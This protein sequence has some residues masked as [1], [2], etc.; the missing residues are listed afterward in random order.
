[1]I[2]SQAHSQAISP[3][4]P[5]SQSLLEERERLHE[6]LAS[7]RRQNQ[8]LQERVFAATELHAETLETDT[9]PSL[10]AH[11]DE[12]IAAQVRKR[13]QVAPP[14][15]LSSSVRE[16]TGGV[17]FHSR[18]GTE[19]SSQRPRSDPVEAVRVVCRYFDSRDD[20]GD[21]NEEQVGDEEEDSFFLR[22]TP[23][24]AT[25]EDLKEEILRFWRVPP[26]QRLRY[27][28]E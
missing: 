5:S 1:M 16:S 21:L 14:S 11:V 9:L 8:E 25:F 10:Y 12:L 23:E 18:F 19:L 17:N 3:S 20:G 24:L 26:I 28:S 7:I 15:S 13:S 6:Q 4:S 22:L 2:D 27:V